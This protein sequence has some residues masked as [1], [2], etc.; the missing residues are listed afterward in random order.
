MRRPS[1]KI[2]SKESPPKLLAGFI[3]FYI[4]YITFFKNCSMVTAHC[5]S[6]SHRLKINFQDENF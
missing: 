2:A 1:S 4:F 5:I 3:S 6:R